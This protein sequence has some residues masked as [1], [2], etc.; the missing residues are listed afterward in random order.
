MEGEEG[1]ESLGQLWKMGCPEHAVP[2]RLRLQVPGSHRG[3][4][5]SEH[6]PL[7]SFDCS[8]YFQTQGEL[9]QLFHRL[10]HPG[11]EPENYSAIK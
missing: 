10:R 4:G 8:N 3:R 1:A 11:A 5:C 2:L 9:T 7:H 6:L